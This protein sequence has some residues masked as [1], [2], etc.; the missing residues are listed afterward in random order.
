MKKLIAFLSAGLMM[1]AVVAPALAVCGP[2]SQ[3]G[4]KCCPRIEIVNHNRANVTTTADSNSNTGGNAQRDRGNDNIITGA[5]YSN[6][7]ADSWVNSN[8]NTVRVGRLM[9]PIGINNNNGA[10]VRTDADADSNTGRNHQRSSGFGC[11]TDTIRT[12]SASSLSG[13]ESYV[14]SNTSVV[15]SWGSWIW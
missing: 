7:W 3:P 14:N 4:K 11:G 15:R 12:G 6:S 9:G 13:A 1:V 2:C 5:A 10:V 8:V